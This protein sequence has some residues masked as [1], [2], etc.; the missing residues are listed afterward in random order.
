MMQLVE[1]VTTEQ[2][3]EAYYALLGRILARKARMG[4]I[5]L[6]YVGLP[7]AVEFAQ[8]GF[9]VTGIED[10]VRDQLSFCG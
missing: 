9:R 10:S 8:A 3:V 5:G 1:T 7:E 2:P 6:G 4:V